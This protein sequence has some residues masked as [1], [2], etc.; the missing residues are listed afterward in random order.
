MVGAIAKARQYTRIV[1]N[2]AHSHQVQ[3]RWR[4]GDAQNHVN[5]AVFLT[6]LEEGRDSFLDSRLGPNFPYAVVRVELDI[7]RELELAERVIEVVIDAVE[8]G[9]TSFTT[10]ESVFNRS[11]TAIA[12][13]KVVSVK[14]DRGKSTALTD[15][16]RRALLV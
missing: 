15:T 9:R 11:G 10:T 1:P 2:S 12:R 14:W 16:E 3:I 6:Y 8:V 13:A 7:L 5:H 4:D